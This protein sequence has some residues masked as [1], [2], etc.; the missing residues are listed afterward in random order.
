MPE[1]DLLVSLRLA[2]AKI[3]GDETEGELQVITTQKQD[4]IPQAIAP[5]WIDNAKYG[6]EKARKGIKTPSLKTIKFHGAF[7]KDAV[8][9]VPLEK[10][11]RSDDIHFWGFS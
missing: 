6:S 11:N 2:T 7:L 1:M 5:R 8:E 9:Q 4:C 10:M 3:W